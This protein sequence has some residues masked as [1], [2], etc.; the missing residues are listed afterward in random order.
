MDLGRIVDRC[1]EG[2]LDSVVQEDYIGN[3]VKKLR[4]CDV[5]IYSSSLR[6]PEN[7][8]DP[9]QNDEKQKIVHST[10]KKEKSPGNKE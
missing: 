3:I 2:K 4:L 10:P 5:K 7:Y 6:K 8:V 1:F 9:R